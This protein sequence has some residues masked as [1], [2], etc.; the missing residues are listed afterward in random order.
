[1]YEKI[2]EAWV[3]EYENASLQQLDDGFFRKANEYLKSL[4]KLGGEGLA[5][6]LASIKRRRVEYMLLDLKRMR[7]EKILSCITEGKP[8]NTDALTGN[9]RKVYDAILRTSEIR[10]EEEELEELE[11]LD[12]NALVTVRILVDLPE[13]VGADL[14]VYG[15]FK[16][17]DVASLPRDNAIALIRKGAAMPI[18]PE[19]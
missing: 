1:M 12:E 5:A 16:A 10:F 8:V 9:E 2:F 6:E 17:E 4:S 11:N 19:K 14:K 15:P 7:L 13:I 18:I 3:K